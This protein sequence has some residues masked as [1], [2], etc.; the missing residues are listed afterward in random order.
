MELPI[1][2]LDPDLIVCVKPA[3]WIS[4]PGSGKS[5]PLALAEQLAAAGEDPTLHTVHRLDKPVAGLMVLAR[6]HRA[7]A[8]LIDQIAAHRTEKEYLAVVRGIPPEQEGT[9][10]DLLFHDS[11]V[12]K[13]YVVKRLR[14]G[15]RPAKLS[16]RVLQT[17][18]GDGQPISLVRVRL[19][20]G[21]THQ[22]RAQFSARGLPLL[23]DVR[24]GSKASHNLALFSCLLAFDHPGSHTRMRFEEFPKGEP[25]SAFQTLD[26]TRSE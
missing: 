20:T 19:Y 2:H 5:L 17:L 25:W 1:I 3:G 9:W 15:V 13:T 8:D 12:N 26:P 24:Y 6:N 4:E 23:G 21:R 18:E 14:K 10:E 16:Y 22:I 11:R 7:A